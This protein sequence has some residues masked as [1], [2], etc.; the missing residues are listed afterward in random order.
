MKKFTTIVI[1]VLLLIIFVS[2]LFMVQVRET[3]VAVLKVGGKYASGTIEPGLKFKIP[4]FR[5]YEKFDKRVRITETKTTQ[6]QDSKNAPFLVQVYVGWK[7][8]D[9]KI[10]EL[11]QFFSA[12][13]GESDGAN[14]DSE[15][16]LTDLEN[17]VRDKLKEPLEKVGIEVSFV[18]I[19]R[20][21]VPPETTK[22]VFTN[23]RTERQFEQTRITNE[24]EKKRGEIIQRANLEAGKRLASAQRE[25]DK[26]RADAEAAAKDS[27]KGLEKHPELAMFLQKLK[28]LES[29]LK[30]K[31]TLILDDRVP[32]F[33][34]LNGLRTNQLPKPSPAAISQP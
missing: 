32:P 9:V 10:Y 33:D 34:L 29:T 2:L 19:K 27:Y 1:A 16:S 6:T 30:Q 22:D 17:D 14:A 25:A 15:K 13:A 31:T 18:G 28:M 23:M 21:I 8:N 5:E 11:G 12:N 4:F 3:E 24:G 26:T 20:L 7:I